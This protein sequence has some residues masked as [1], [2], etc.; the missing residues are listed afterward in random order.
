M[1]NIQ[2]KG[3]DEVKSLEIDR[4]SYMKLARDVKKRSGE[5][6]NDI[7]FFFFAILAFVS[8]YEKSQ[9]AHRGRENR[10]RTGD[11]KKTTVPF[12]DRESIK[13][14]RGLSFLE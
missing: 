11:A 12:F 6:K 3:D 1:S 10:D 14:K 8:A 9:H 4:E 2:L 7:Y 5:L 13:S